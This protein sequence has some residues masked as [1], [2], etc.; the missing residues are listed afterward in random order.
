MSGR[1]GGSN[2]LLS[3]HEAAEY[4]GLSYKYYARSYLRFGITYYR[5]G[6]Y[7]RF[8]VRDLDAW[9]ESTRNKPAP[10]PQAHTETP[11]AVARGAPGPAQAADTQA[12]YS[13]SSAVVPC[14]SASGSK[15]P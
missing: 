11:R 6:R 13:A 12:E 14:S 1:I 3:M 9:L 7:V 15:C 2:V 5:V 8:R 10:I 4:V